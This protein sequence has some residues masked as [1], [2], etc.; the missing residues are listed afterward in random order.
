MALGLDLQVRPVVFTDQRPI[1]NL[2]HVSPQ[3]HRHLDWRN[4]L[5]WIGSP[6]FLLAEYAGRLAAVLACPPDP[7]RVAWI[8]L[9][10]NSGDLPVEATWP[11]LWDAVRNVL[12]AKGSFVM[13]AIALQDWYADLLDASGFTCRQKI[14]M[15]ERQGGALTPP[16]QPASVSIR[17]MMPYDLPAVAKVDAAAFAPLWQNTLPALNRAYPQAALATV[18]EKDGCLIGYQISTPNPFGAHLARLAVLPEAQGQHVGYALVDDLIRQLAQRGADRLTV[19]T[20]SDNPVSLRLYQQMGF[21]LTGEQYP[22]YE[23]EV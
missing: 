13:A 10:L 20:Q 16:T 3:V 6:P 11:F 18:A 19:N 12:T 9:F 8:R 14:V 23:F 7:P 17:R 5:D 21:R 22:V 1:A 15:L 4:P 2:L